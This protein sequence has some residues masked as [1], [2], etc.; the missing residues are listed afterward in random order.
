MHQLHNT[1]VG[2]GK[3]ETRPMQNHSG[4]GIAEADAI[5]LSPLIIL[6]NVFA[7]FIFLPNEVKNVS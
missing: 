6:W 3:M 1:R 2:L 5:H 4:G 7:V